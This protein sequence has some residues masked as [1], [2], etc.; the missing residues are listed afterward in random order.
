MNQE[1]VWTWNAQDYARKKDRGGITSLMMIDAKCICGRIRQV[2]VPPGDFESKRITEEPCEC[3]RFMC[4]IGVETGNRT[5]ID[6][7]FETE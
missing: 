5:P 6:L 1:D 3:G 4:A 7:M 2:P